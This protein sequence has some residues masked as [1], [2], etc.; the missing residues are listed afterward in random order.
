MSLDKCYNIEKLR[1][2]AKSKIPSPMFHYID[3]GAGDEITLR[4]NT[5]AFDKYA[6]IPNGLRDV[7]TIDTSSTLMGRKLSWPLMMAPTGMNRL[8]H[9]DKE[10]GVARA[11][12]K[13]GVFLGLSTVA[14]TSIADVAAVND[15]PKMYQLYVFKDRYM[16]ENMIEACRTNNYDAICLTIDTVVGG[17]RER[18]LMT[19]FTVPP[20]FTLASL[21]SFGM[22]PKWVFYALTQR[23]FKVPNVEIYGSEIFKG[24]KSVAQNINE[25]F[26]RSINWEDV[27]WLRKIWDGKLVIKGVHSVHDAKMCVECGVDAIMI[28]N[29]GGRQM[30]SV[31]GAIECLPAIK[32][33]VGDKMELIVDGGIRRGNHIIKALALGATAVS[34][35]KAYLYGLAAGGEAGVDKVLNILRSEFERD[36]T[37]MGCTKISDITPDHIRRFDE[38]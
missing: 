38:L 30:D 23:N 3:G 17:N 1:L 25:Q 36:M 11:A 5:S 26:D 28:S 2:K 21:I 10:I 6:L 29:H 32:A 12:K 20:K 14:S 18:D 31:P 15:G 8:F 9:H 7:S 35:G 4:R 27:K 13:S 33:A 22:R 16:T 24:G 37:L 34:I 19:G